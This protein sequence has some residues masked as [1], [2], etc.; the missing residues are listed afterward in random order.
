[1]DLPELYTRRRDLQRH[2]L[3]AW[4]NEEFPLAVTILNTIGEVD[5]QIIELGG[6]VRGSD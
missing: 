2:F 5:D 1:M 3:R 6:E 4:S